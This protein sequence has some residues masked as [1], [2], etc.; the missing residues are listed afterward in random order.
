MTTDNSVKKPRHA[1]VIY[2]FSTLWV[3][4]YSLLTPIGLCLATSSL[5]SIIC[6]DDHENTAIYV[7]LAHGLEN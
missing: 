5:F 4:K 7:N 6:T 1:K 2:L 3:W